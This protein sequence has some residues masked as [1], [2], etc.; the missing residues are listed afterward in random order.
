MKHVFV[1]ITASDRNEAESISETII[2]EHLVACTNILDNMSALFHWENAVQK[3]QEV[4]LIAKTTVS[5][6]PLLEKRV[7][8]LHS[9]D[10]PCI[11]AFPIVMGNDD[12]LKWIDDE[13]SA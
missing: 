11:I 13:V 12:Y 7:K 6:F 5:A 9:Y 2:S 4:V 8:E 1:Y 3:E 10:C